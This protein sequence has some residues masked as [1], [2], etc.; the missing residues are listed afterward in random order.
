MNPNHAEE[1]GAGWGA[2][3]GEGLAR[4]GPGDRCLSDPE[5][6]GGKTL[7]PAVP[8]G[9]TPAGSAR[10]FGLIGAALLLLG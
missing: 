4:R 2:Q 10:S 6:E 1:A 9:S 8:A 5:T 7:T 3:R